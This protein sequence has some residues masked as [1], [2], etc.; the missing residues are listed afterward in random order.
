MYKGDWYYLGTDGAMVKG[1]QTSGGK[2]YY[3]DQ[4]GK[5]TMEPVTLTQIRTEPCSVRGWQYSRKWAVCGG[6]FL[7]KTVRELYYKHKVT[8]NRVD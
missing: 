6:S 7:T 4:E 3:L 1:L 8:G 2:W 5:L